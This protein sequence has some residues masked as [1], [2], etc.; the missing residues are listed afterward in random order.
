MQRRL[1]LVARCYEFGVLGRRGEGADA[2]VGGEERPGVV[3]GCEDVSVSRW[4]SCGSWMRQVGR[5]HVRLDL[6]EW[7]GFGG[8]HDGSVM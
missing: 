4:V 5:W 3:Q 7:V 8:R 2:L 1:E 6:E